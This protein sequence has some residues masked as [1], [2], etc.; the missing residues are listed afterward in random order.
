MM[1]KR[2][3]LLTKASTWV[4][5][6]GLVALNEKDSPVVRAGFLGQLYLLLGLKIESAGLKV[7]INSNFAAFIIPHFWRGGLSLYS[8]SLLLRMKISINKDT[9]LKWGKAG[10]HYSGLSCSSHV[11]GSLW[12]SPGPD[13][14]LLEG[15]K[16]HGDSF[17]WGSLSRPCTAPVPSS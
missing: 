5:S 13:A 9:P 2:L 7:F 12:E 3:E 17:H 14:G 11:Y 4:W 6:L 15:R 8:H 10:S 16:R 1:H